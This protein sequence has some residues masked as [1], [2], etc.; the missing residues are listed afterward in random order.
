VSE[1]RFARNRPAGLRAL[2]GYYLLLESSHILVILWAGFRF[3]TTGEIGF[4]APPP[5]GGW[6]EGVIPWLVGN[7]LLDLFFAAAGVLFGVRFLRRRGSWFRWGVISLTGALYSA[8]IFAI[9]TIPSGAWTA[10][11]LAYGLLAAAFSP[12]LLILVLL[13]L[14]TPGRGP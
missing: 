1:V 8:G 13:L 14:T 4:P 7:G 10:H 3:S 9:G 12:I 5:P 11:P 2:V 6:P